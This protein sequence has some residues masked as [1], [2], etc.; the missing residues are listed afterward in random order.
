MFLHG[1]VHTLRVCDGLTMSEAA[2]KTAS[3]NCDH[4]SEY[5]HALNGPNL[6]ERSKKL[7]KVL[8]KLTWWLAGFKPVINS[9]CLYSPSSE[10]W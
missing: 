7:K 2:R 8:I 3:K 4:L 5:L 10:V 6:L 1:L 9:L